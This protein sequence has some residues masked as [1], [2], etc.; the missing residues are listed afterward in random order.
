MQYACHL[1]E[2]ADPYQSITEVLKTSNK[3]PWL[4]NLYT[5]ADCQV[6]GSC[7]SSLCKISKDQPE[8]GEGYHNPEVHPQLH[9]QLTWQN[10]VVDLT[11]CAGHMRLYLK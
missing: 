8:E 9:S 5:P 11:L 1:P 3:L 10:A 4:D 2:S 6:T 7:G